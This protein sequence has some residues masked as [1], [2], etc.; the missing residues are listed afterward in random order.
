MMRKKKI[1]F[2]VA[3]GLVLLAGA[4]T[5]IGIYA[6]Q[7]NKYENI[8]PPKGLSTTPAAQRQV[9]GTADFYVSPNGND[10]N[11]G[12]FS[13]PFATIEQAQ[14]AVR[15]KLQAEPEREKGI[16]VAVMAG[17]YQ[18]AGL[19]FSEADSGTANAPVTYT[20]YGDG[21]VVLNGGVALQA[22]D[23]QP[24]SGEA[25]DRIPASA[26]QQ[27]RVLDLSAYNLSRAQ[28]GELGSFGGFHTGE[29]YDSNPTGIN[30]CELFF[31]GTRLT[32]AR[33]PNEGYLKT[34]QVLDIGDAYEPNPPGPV[35]ES[36]LTRRNQRGGT[37]M[38]DEDT[39]ARVQSWKST[40]DVWMYGYFFWDWADM[41]TPV[42]SVDSAKKTITTAYCS[43]YGFKEGADYYFYNVLEE[44]DAPGEYYIDRAANKLYLYPPKALENASVT[45]SVTTDS[46]LT[47]DE[48]ASNLIFDG[49]TIEGTRADAVV[50]QGENC[51]LRSCTVQNAAGA[52][53]CVSGTNNR[54]ENCEVCH[55]GTDAVV[56]GGGS[57]EGFTPG[58]NVADNN[59]LHDFGEIQKT[60]IAGVNISGIGN[61]ASHNEIFNAPHMGI[62]YTGND[63]IMEYNF[64]HDVVLQSSDA[65]AIYTGFNLSTYG[66][67]VRYNC[68]SN[69]GSG[70]FTPNGIYFDD[71]SSGQT[72]YGNVLIN[73]PGYAILVGG[74]RDHDIRNNL[75][76]NA[77]TALHYDDRA[78]EGYH[79][80]GW[81]AK[82]CKAPDSMLWEKFAE[83]KT[84]NEQSGGKYEGIA[85]MHQD[86]NRT[87]DAGFA[88]NPSGSVVTDNI[89]IT[90]KGK[91]GFVADSVWQYSSVDG[92]SCYKLSKADDSFADFENG[93]YMLLADSKIAAENP[94]F[95]PIPFS[96]IG[97]K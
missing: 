83:A 71:V 33:Y 12:S 86:Y 61:T 18:T 41:S 39:F 49:F 88:V 78:Y 91:L 37:F 22:E 9:V 5:A 70:A 89:F 96:E 75:V 29:Y 68:I 50:V 60:Y 8:A 85:R 55:V 52:G 27:V 44:L 58:G 80:D 93:D 35:D 97:R 17:N 72:A 67:V 74:G 13:S 43:K 23:F 3:A 40:D 10:Q 62:Y 63:N 24:V 59:S 11:D 7:Q 54:V 48:T 25:A 66:N 76:I 81:F 47:L 77:G 64:I 20:A 92:N 56:L 6:A 65:G 38:L 84:L 31:D 94:D 42:G 87:E 30:A 34:G 28:Y 79:K 82:N 73:I 26:R 4:G 32:L 53:V 90:K 21:A 36:W 1:F 19:V 51:I 14:K 15:A 95:E 2:A 69:I 16:T 45:L 46:I 57:A